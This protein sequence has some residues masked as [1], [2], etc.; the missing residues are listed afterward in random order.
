[1][2]G[3]LRLVAKTLELGWRI[4]RGLFKA[5]LFIIRHIF[6]LFYG[7][8]HTFGSARF[9]N[10]ADLKEAGMLPGSGTRSE[11]SSGLI[12]GQVKSGIIRA[13]DSDHLL[14]MAPTKSGKTTCFVNTNILKLGGDAS[15]IIND[16]NGETYAVTKRERERHGEVFLWAPFAEKSHSL[17]PL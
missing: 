7:K 12:L 4:S 11:A 2:W 17:N 14:C 10:R 3:I 9:A 15:A 6:K 8:R 16:P 5:K 13:P 1:M